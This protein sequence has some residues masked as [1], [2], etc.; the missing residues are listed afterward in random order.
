MISDK[1][2]LYGD[3][4]RKAYGFTYS[5]SDYENTKDSENYR[6]LFSYNYTKKLRENNWS[7]AH[8]ARLLNLSRKATSKYRTGNLPSPRIFK[9]LCDVFECDYQD[10]F[11]RD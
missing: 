4:K 2:Q 11:K 10:F 8:I 5:E 3:T 7:S 6:N 9:M 1:T